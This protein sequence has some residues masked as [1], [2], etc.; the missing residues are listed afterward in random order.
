MLWDSSS[1]IFYAYSRTTLRCSHGKSVEGGILVGIYAKKNF[2]GK[3][4]GTGW[5]VVELQE[6]QCQAPL[7]GLYGCKFNAGGANIACGRAELDTRINDM[8]IV[9]PTRF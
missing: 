7:A 1:K 3:T 8:A 2:L 6:G 9:E 4:P 5:W